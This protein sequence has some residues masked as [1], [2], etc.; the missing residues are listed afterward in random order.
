MITLYPVFLIS[1]LL[2]LPFHQVRPT[3]SVGGRPFQSATMLIILLIKLLAFRNSLL[4]LIQTMSYHNF[5]GEHLMDLPQS[6]RALHLSH[7][8]SFQIA[9]DLYFLTKSSMLCSQNA[10]KRFTSPM[11]TSCYQHRLVAGRQLS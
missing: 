3:K 4:L 7:L 2:L 8:M 1:V 10:S 5:V 9:S 11:T 6:F